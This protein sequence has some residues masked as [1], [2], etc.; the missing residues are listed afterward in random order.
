MHYYALVIVPAEGD[1]DELVAEA[2]APYDENEH[3]EEY[4]DAK[5]GETYQRNPHSLWDWY[6]IGG[7]WT[8]RLSG[9]DPDTDPTLRE[10]C[11]LCKGTGRR[12]DEVAQRLRA[13]MP[14]YTCNG[15]E[16]TGKMRLWPTQ[17][18][19]HKGDVMSALEFT[20][21]LAEWTDN[22][23]PYAVITHGSESVSVKERWNGE[24]FEKLHDDNSIRTVLA[25]ILS[26]RIKAGLSDRVVVVDYH[27]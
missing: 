12:D 17:W 7:R 5:Y 18:P 26:A 1:L 2:M 14:N 10:T 20:S 3:L 11:W 24:T 27:S 6:Q 22:Q 19:R 8:G 15:C 13:T 21:R 4:Y 16:G 9:Y 25:T 23:L